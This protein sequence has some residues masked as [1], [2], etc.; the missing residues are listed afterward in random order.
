M[1][2]IF[3]PIMRNTAGAIHAVHFIEVLHIF[4]TVNPSM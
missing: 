1:Q 3:L 2:G 4:F